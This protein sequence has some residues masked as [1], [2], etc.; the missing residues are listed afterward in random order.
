VN[1]TTPSSPATKFSGILSE[2]TVMAKFSHGDGNWL[3][4]VGNQRPE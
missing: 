3:L 1:A 4:P 2:M